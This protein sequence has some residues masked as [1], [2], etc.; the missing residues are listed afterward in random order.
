[1]IVG[2]P[3]PVPSFGS[4]EEQQKFFKDFADSVRPE[5]ERLA[6]ARMQSEMDSR[7]LWVGPRRPDTSGNR[8]KEN[9]YLSRICNFFGINY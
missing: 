4:Y 2:R 3:A 8:Y 6:R 1:M 7:D 5:L 9:S